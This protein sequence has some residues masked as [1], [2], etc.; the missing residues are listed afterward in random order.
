MPFEVSLRLPGL[1]VPEDADYINDCCWGGDVIAGHLSPHVKERYRGVASGQED[2]GWYVWI[3]DR[4]YRLEVDIFC[5]S[6]EGAEFRIHLVSTRRRRLLPNV[7]VDL[8][9][10]DDLKAFVVPILESWSGRPC[11]VARLDAKGY[12]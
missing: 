6:R 10:L 1:S 9:S 4:D 7:I 8:P 3:T 2:W 12:R 5:D 11:G